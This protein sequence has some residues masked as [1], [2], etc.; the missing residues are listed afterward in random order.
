MVIASGAHEVSSD[1]L[2]IMQMAS[3]QKEEMTEVDGHVQAPASIHV[4]DIPLVFL[5]S[6]SAAG[7]DEE[8]ESET[9]GLA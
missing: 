2:N 4:R 9:K 3:T 8:P 5:P 1:E 7:E 6:I